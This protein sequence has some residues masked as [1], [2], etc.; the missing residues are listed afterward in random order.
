MSQFGRLLHD[1]TFSRQFAAVVAIAVM[2]MAFAS[3]LAISWQSSRQIR[4]NL[5]EQ[6]RQITDNL[7]RQSKL[8]LLY[9]AP[10]NASEAVTVTLAF[11]DVTSLEVRHADGRLLLSRSKS[12]GVENG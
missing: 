6:G 9:E 10:E 3:S 2:S 7:A 12:A 11:P 8:A 5:L 4:T 1:T